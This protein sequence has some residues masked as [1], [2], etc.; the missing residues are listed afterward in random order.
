MT[1]KQFEMILR[2]LRQA[3]EHNTKQSVIDQID[4]MLNDTGQDKKKTPPAGTG[5]ADTN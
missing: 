1:T 3:L 2:G 4:A 5:D